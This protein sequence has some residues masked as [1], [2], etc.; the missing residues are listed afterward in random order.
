[1]PD[2]TIKVNLK[3]HQSFI[4]FA[5]TNTSTDHSVYSGVFGVT[6]TVDYI[7]AHMGVGYNF[8]G[9]VNDQSI[10]LDPPRAW[11]PP[12][13]R[14]SGYGQDSD[15]SWRWLSFITGFSGGFTAGAPWP[16]R[17]AA[18]LAGVTPGTPPTQSVNF[19]FYS[20]QMETTSIAEW[21][22]WGVRRFHIHQPFGRIRKGRNQ[23][24]QQYQMDSFVCARDGFRDDSISVPSNNSEILEEKR[25]GNIPMPWITNDVVD[26]ITQGFVPLWKALITGTAGDLSNDMW[27]RLTGIG[28][29]SAWFDP[30]DPITVSAYTGAINHETFRRWRRWFDAGN[31]IAGTTTNG[32]GID[33]NGVPIATFAR[34]RMEDS[35]SPFIRTGMRLGFDALVGAPG[36]VVGQYSVGAFPSKTNAGE[37]LGYTYD[38]DQFPGNDEARLDTGNTFGAT[39]DAAWWNFFS[40]YAVPQL[41]RNNIYQEAI[42]YRCRD[43]QGNAPNPY[44][45]F[46]VITVDEFGRAGY[47]DFGSANSAHALHE[48][49]EVEIARST[50]WAGNPHIGKINTQTGAV[51]LNGE[52]WFLGASAG[53]PSGTAGSGLPALSTNEEYLRAKRVHLYGQDN[54][55]GYANGWSGVELWGA[56]TLAKHLIRKQIHQNDPNSMGDKTFSTTLMSSDLLFKLPDYRFATHQFDFSVILEQY[57]ETGISGDFITNFPN[58]TSYAKW[59]APLR[60]G[61]VAINPRFTHAGLT[62][63]IIDIEPLASE[64][65][66]VVRNMDITDNI[67]GVMWLTVADYDG[68]ASTNLG[69]ISGGA[70]YTPKTLATEV[71]NTVGTPHTDIDATKFYNWMDVKIQ[72][73]MDRFGIAPKYIAWKLSEYNVAG[74]T[75]PSW[76]RQPIGFEMERYLFLPKTI[77]TTANETPDAYK[78]RQNYFASVP[79]ITWGPGENSER[80]ENN[81]YDIARSGSQT[82]DPKYTEAN[83]AAIN[84]IT[85]AKSW[86]TSRNLNAKVGVYNLPYLPKSA[87]NVYAI[88]TSAGTGPN[89]QVIVSNTGNWN[90]RV[91]AKQNTQNYWFG[92][93]ITGWYTEVE[94]ATIKNAVKL[95]YR[96]RLESVTALCEVLFAPMYNSSSEET[97][98]IDPTIESNKQW[99]TQVLELGNDLK[100]KPPWDTINTTNENGGEANLTCELQTLVNISVVDPELSNFPSTFTPVDG[101]PFTK[102]QGTLFNHEQVEYNLIDWIR[103]DY[104]RPKHRATQRIQGMSIESDDLYRANNAIKTGNYTGKTADRDWIVKWIV[105]EDGAGA[106]IDWSNTSDVNTK[107]RRFF[108][109]RNNLVKRYLDRFNKGVPRKSIH[110]PYTFSPFAA[111]WNKGFSGPT[112]GYY[113]SSVNGQAITDVVPMIWA[114]SQIADDGVGFDGGRRSPG[115]TGNMSSVQFARFS[116]MA[117]RVPLGKRVMLPWYWL[118][119]SPSGQVIGADYY[120]AGSDGCTY[121]G[122]K[123]RAHE[124]PGSV[125]FISPWADN[126]TQD[127]KSAF[128]AF[129][130]Q[131]G[132]SGT[133]FDQIANDFEGFYHLKLES[134]QNTFENPFGPTGM[135][136]GLTSIGGEKVVIPWNNYD[137]IPD[138]R[139]TQS[140]VTDPRFSSQ[141]LP[142]TGLTFGGSVEKYYYETR[143]FADQMRLNTGINDNGMTAAQMLKHYI[144]EGP[145]GISAATG[146]ASCAS[147]WVLGDAVNGDNR[148]NSEPGS[149]WKAP[150]SVSES[151]PITSTTSVSIKRAWFAW[152]KALSDL[153]F[154]GHMKR[155]WLDTLQGSTI[156]QHRNISYNHYGYSPVGVTE[157]ALFMEANMHPQVYD[158]NF[159]LS[160]TGADIG[161]APILYGEADDILRAASYYSNPTTDSQ[162]Y[163][164]ALYNPE[165]SISFGGATTAK[166]YISFINELTRLRANLRSS[167]NCWKKLSPWLKSPE[168]LWFMAGFWVGDDNP[169]A[170]SYEVEYLRELAF[171]TLLSGAQYINYFN[172]GAD[173]TSNSTGFTAGITFMQGVFDTWKV[174][175]ES[176]RVQPASN[177]TGDVN[178]LME[179]ILLS[180]AGGNHG[181]LAGFTGTVTSGGKLLKYVSGKTGSVAFGGENNDTYLW[182]ISVPPQAVGGTYARV[183]YPSAAAVADLPAI[184]NIPANETGF[185]IKRKANSYKPVYRFL[186]VPPV[187]IPTERYDLVNGAGF[188]GLDPNKI[189]TDGDA[190]TQVGGTGYNA[191]IRVIAAWK[192][193][194][195]PFDTSTETTVTVCA[196]H[197]SGIKSVEASLNG[198]YTA[199]RSGIPSPYPSY[200]EFIFNIQPNASNSDNL[201]ATTGFPTGTLHE[202]RAK[203]YPNVGLPRILGGKPNDLSRYYPFAN[204][205]VSLMGSLNYSTKLQANETSYYLCKEDPQV[206]EIDPDG[207]NSLQAHQYRDIR[208]AIL[209]E[210]GDTNQDLVRMSPYNYKFVKFLVTG[211]PTGFT[212]G[213]PILGDT[214][215]D[216]IDSLDVVDNRGEAVVGFQGTRI[217]SVDWSSQNSFRAIVIESDSA[218]PVVPVITART[219]P[220]T[221]NPSPPRPATE[222]FTTGTPGTAFLVDNTYSVRNIDGVINAYCR[223]DGNI[224]RLNRKATDI[225][226]FKPTIFTGILIAP[227]GTTAN[228]ADWIFESTV[229]DYVA[230]MANT[231]SV[232]AMRIGKIKFKNVKIDRGAI[233]EFTASDIQCQGVTFFSSLQ[234]PTEQSV[235]SSVASS[236]FIGCTTDADLPTRYGFNDARRVVDCKVNNSYSDVMRNPLFVYNSSATGAGQKDIIGANYLGRTVFNRKNAIIY[237]STIDGNDGSNITL[238]T[239]GGTILGAVGACADHES[240]VYKNVT[241]VGITGQAN[242]LVSQINGNVHQVFY[243]GVSFGSQ[244]INI[245][246][247]YRVVNNNSDIVPFGGKPQKLYIKDSTFNNI[248]YEDSTAM[249]PLPFGTPIGGSTLGIGQQFSVNK[250]DQ[251]GIATDSITTIKTKPSMNNVRVYIR[252]IPQASNITPTGNQFSLY[253]KGLGE[254]SSG[255]TYSHNYGA[256]IGWSGGTFGSTGDVTTYIPPINPTVGSVLTCGV[257]FSTFYGTKYASAGITIEPLSGATFY[258]APNNYTDGV[259]NVS[260]GVDIPSTHWLAAGNNGSSW[261][262]A[263]QPTNCV[264]IR[265]PLATD[266]GTDVSIEKGHLLIT[267]QTGPIRNAFRDDWNRPGLS[268]FMLVGGST[269]RLGPAVAASS[270]VVTKIRIGWNSGISAGLPIWANNTAVVGATADFPDFSTGAWKIFYPT[271][272]AVG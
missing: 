260:L 31:S 30:S 240:V 16:Y 58:I 216:Y 208:T 138:N 212:Q 139:A 265:G 175:A 117:N 4:P 229:A 127:S 241:I 119:E 106:T 176:C 191:T 126:N 238:A 128:T 101:D 270:I 173:S 268:G 5:P 262:T 97:I 90:D 136:A 215:N 214:N 204:P 35:L 154:G 53:L 183:N 131:C 63:N 182:R 79:G 164:L 248:V 23:E 87:Y 89:A 162:R 19:D 193:D 75:G 48:M 71:P 93:G 228:N 21:Y 42:P 236:S 37:E 61:A 40:T 180:D 209:F 2:P 60:T 51:T 129:L 95:E 134:L 199:N 96:K 205:P 198:G 160:A 206:A 254:L 213:L 121:F 137:I 163:T 46:P 3:A 223:F 239:G 233:L 249:T 140:I 104:L 8:S 194:P 109:I 38:A 188:D 1:M 234:P 141:V 196:Y 62:A 261:V 65:A 157:G 197:P 34:Q 47:G 100:T 181:G 202:I 29:P 68:F 192:G 123:H 253:V 115:N 44:L 33:T 59:L 219:T 74:E 18:A 111:C 54:P 41:G 169:S 190:D 114:S 151:Y 256:H 6:E 221:S 167:P 269:Y 103:D 14:V 110:D 27:K 211:Q 187:I 200:Q 242:R 153:V 135:P 172:P 36:P 133:V 257:T 66:N 231:R 245:D 80:F 263:I 232:E 150:W 55:G 155:I 56:Y 26:G 77:P 124:T 174:Q 252:G 113:P 218:S 125:K 146:P 20:T 98:A 207:I 243:E 224:Y 251:F 12:G 179:R 143:P 57:A 122:G 112:F 64:Y 220:G 217:A 28:G 107:I 24:T 9:G 15:T 255:E 186:P 108:A 159:P 91:F 145:T 11:C 88:D 120:K 84:M 161:V 70:F 246:N 264:R 132:A 195:I 177:E 49:G 184:V 118:M 149:P 166:A 67:D 69:G 210:M 222:G 203:I 185:W 247:T 39:L 189:F 230:T 45:G 225:G 94:T 142:L 102:S 92:T 116:Q 201:P 250:Y 259:W 227:S 52:Y 72:S 266:A 32:M 244:G 147:Y 171:H 86:R 43:Q 50:H 22:K 85:L 7:Q 76:N 178:A 130:A 258:V 152:N 10:G 168:E 81:G 271:G 17:P 235:L 272:S 148:Y 237:N 13:L 267:S 25:F 105:A 73:W 78:E 165:G 226:P 83:A 82:A 144:F 170:R 99:H 156:Q 158:T